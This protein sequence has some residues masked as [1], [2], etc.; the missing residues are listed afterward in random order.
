[1]YRY[2]L[3]YSPLH[4][5]RVPEGGSRQYPAVLVS[6]IQGSLG[7]HTYSYNCESNYSRGT[8][9][10]L[11]RA[12]FWPTS[13]VL[14]GHFI[15]HTYSNT[16]AFPLLH[17]SLL[18]CTYFPLLSSYLCGWISGVARAQIHCVL[19]LLTT[20]Y[21]ATRIPFPCHRR[22]HLYLFWTQE[23]TSVSYSWVWPE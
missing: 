14:Q 11:S 21:H 5:V 12:W 6:Y 4:N 20:P 8:F 7:P 9:Q 17:S 1:M 15:L 2:I 19:D 18:F 22:L 23:R 16:T 3:P 10:T 13:V